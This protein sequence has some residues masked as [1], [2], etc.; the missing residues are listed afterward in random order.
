MPGLCGCTSLQYFKK[1]QS[2]RLQ[3]CSRLILCQS[4]SGVQRTCWRS[5][6]TAISNFPVFHT[7]AQPTLYFLPGLFGLSNA[8]FTSTFGCRSSL[9]LCSL[10]SSGLL[11]SIFFSMLSPASASAIC[12]AEREDEAYSMR[13]L[14]LEPEGQV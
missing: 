9:I 14:I 6:F 13:S 10:I 5:M 8:F 12:T 2:S 1:L 7:H 11:A 3:E 4:K